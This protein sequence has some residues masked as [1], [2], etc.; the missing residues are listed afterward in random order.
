MKFI[1]NVTHEHWPIKI[2][3]DLDKFCELHKLSADDK[4][5]LS[6][7]CVD[8]AKYA[9][10]TAVK[11]H[12]ESG[13]KDVSPEYDGP[14]KKIEVLKTNVMHDKVYPTGTPIS[15]LPFKPGEHLVEEITVPDTTAKVDPPKDD[16]PPSDDSETPPSNDDGNSDEQP[17]T[18]NTANENQDNDTPPSDD[19]TKLTAKDLKKKTVKELKAMCKERGLTGYSRLNEKELIKLLSE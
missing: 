16:T 18:D 17:P 10:Q 8:D 11:K 5:L 4:K 9:K 19:D 13:S 14:V 15:D 12:Q 6:K 7:F 2:G 1:K 3:D